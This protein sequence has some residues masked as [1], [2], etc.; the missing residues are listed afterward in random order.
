MSISLDSVLPRRYLPEVSALRPITHPLA[1]TL[2]I[3]CSHIQAEI[4]RAHP[5]TALRSLQLLHGRSCSMSESERRRLETYFFAKSS[6]SRIEFI[7]PSE[8]LSF[9]LRAA[10]PS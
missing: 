10:L 9:G 1:H 6:R 4:D 3:S 2:L 5:L 8:E 7:I